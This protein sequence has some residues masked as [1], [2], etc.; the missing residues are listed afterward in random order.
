MTEMLGN[1]LFMARNYEGALSIFEQCE[2]EGKADKNMRRKMVVCYTQLG[3]IQKAAELLLA[4]INE[5]LEFITTTDPVKDDCPCNELVREFETK[6][7]I[8]TESFDFLVALGIL[9][10]YCDMDKSVY[11]FQKATRLKSD[12][13]VV[14]SILGKLQLESKTVDKNN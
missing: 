11:Y 9:W 1:Q 14:N 12:N 2:K 5:D 8:S 4:L 6:L 13:N 10:L 3:K 7:K